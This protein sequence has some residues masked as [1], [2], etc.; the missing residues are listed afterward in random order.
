MYWYMVILFIYSVLVYLFPSIWSRKLW[1]SHYFSLL[2][3][4]L[5]YVC[6]VPGWI[7]LPLNWKRE[8]IAP[9]LGLKRILP[10]MVF[11]M[12]SLGNFFLESLYDS[13]L[14]ICTYNNTDTLTH[15]KWKYHSNNTSCMY[16]S[17]CS[18]HW[19]FQ[20][21]TFKISQHLSRSTPRTALL[22]V[23][24][25]DSGL[26]IGLFPLPLNQLHS[27]ITYRAPRQWPSE[28]N[29]SRLDSTPTPPT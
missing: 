21:P 10:K 4:S 17:R 2:F 27:K 11:G 23:N 6:H 19:R 3:I 8:Y 9:L 1:W 29:W 18:L 26:F 14:Y 22:V 16:I 28:E 24:S 13:V 20:I 12:Q 15:T 7:A 25:F 5:W